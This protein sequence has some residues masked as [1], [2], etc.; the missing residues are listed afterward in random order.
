MCQGLNYWSRKVVP[1]PT[2]DP[3]TL[4]PNSES[5][6]AMTLLRFVILLAL[7]VWVGG[8]IFFAFVLA[9]T[10]FSVLP[11]HELAGRVVSRS[12]TALHW[13]GV[14]S[15]L[16]FLV[17][18]MIL[19]KATTGTAHPLATR[20]VLVLLM[21]VL[22]MVSQLAISGKMLTLRS[23]MG[24][25]DDVPTTDARRVA[26]NRLHEWSTRIEGSVLLLGLAALYL[27]A[28]QQGG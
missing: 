28:K 8:I 18:S 24:V 20:H 17:T 15:G 16:V 10:A 11:T 2:S 14:V 25:I 6:P 7:V 21:I 13:I 3:K 1:S 23:Q 22:T 5:N 4:S 27:A 19:T 9:P 12:L 26:F